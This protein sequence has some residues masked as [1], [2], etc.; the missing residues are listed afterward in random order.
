M[1]GLFCL[2]GRHVLKA[3]SSRSPHCSGADHLLWKIAPHRSLPRPTRFA[4]HV[5]R[6]HNTTACNSQEIAEF[7]TLHL[8]LLQICWGWKVL[9]LDRAEPNKTNRKSAYPPN[10]VLSHRKWVNVA[11][12]LITKF[13]I[14]SRSHISLFLFA[15]RPGSETRVSHWNTLH[16]LQHILMLI[17]PFRWHGTLTLPCS[18]VCPSLWYCWI[19]SLCPVAPCLALRSSFASWSNGNRSLNRLSYVPR[20]LYRDLLCLSFSFV[21]SQPAT[22]QECSFMKSRRKGG[23]S[24]LSTICV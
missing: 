5:Y 18:R 1:Y 3:S 11:K 13:T 6:F 2:S 8:Q 12:T 20:T 23:C 4:L 9:F 14:N 21:P 10:D 22:G 19:A 15:H 24:T 17:V 7:T 16:A